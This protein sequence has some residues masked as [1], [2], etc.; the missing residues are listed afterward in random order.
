MNNI[1]N[2]IKDIWRIKSGQTTTPPDIINIEV[3]YMKP[4]SIY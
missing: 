1:I 2:N 4:V 3:T